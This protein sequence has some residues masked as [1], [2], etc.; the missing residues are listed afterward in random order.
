VL[1]G[2]FIAVSPDKVF[3]GHIFSNAQCSLG[4]LLK[5]SP[6]HTPSVISNARI[7]ADLYQVAQVPGLCLCKAPVKNLQA[8]KIMISPVLT[9]TLAPK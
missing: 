3:H 5:K 4:T 2:E 1:F 9:W 8:M 6:L 7:L